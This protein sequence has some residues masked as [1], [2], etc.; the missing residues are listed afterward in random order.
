[1][2]EKYD[3]L[4]E[5]VLDMGSD[6]EKVEEKGQKA[7]GKRARKSLQEIKK[8][9]QELRLGIMDEIR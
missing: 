4:K 3:L 6:I 9:A 7:A 8:L 1:M 5:M 2:Q